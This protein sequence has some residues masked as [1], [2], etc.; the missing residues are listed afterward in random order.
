[1]RFYEF[2]YYAGAAAKKYFSI[3]SR[4][5]LPFPVI[6]IGNITVGGTGKTP[7][8]MAVAE[9]AKRRG[10]RPV[11]LTRGYRGTAKGPCFVAKGNGPSL[12]PEEAGDE[13]YLMAEK[14]RDVAIVKG[15]DRY[16]AGMFAIANIAQLTPSKC[17][18]L[19]ILDDGF[20]HRRL[21]RDEDIVLI[22][23]CNPF[24][25]GKL[26]P[27]GRLREPVDSIADADIIVLT[28]A[29]LPMGQDGTSLS[30][31][32]CEAGRDDFGK[33]YDEIRRHNPASPIFLAGHEPVS[34]SALSGE[35]YPVSFI[36]GR[37]IFAF[38]ALGNPGSFRKTILSSGAELVGFRTYRDHHKYSVSDI[39]AIKSEAGRSGADWIVTTEKD[40]IKIKKFGMPENLLV[41]EIDFTAEKGLYAEVFKEIHLRGDN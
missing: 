14:L 21:Y 29:G 26:L 18:L 4:R 15:G 28:K 31:A 11:I 41:M 1:M 8:A 5:R 7:A 9:E 33:L 40:I 34:L 25:N 3:F 6:S 39:F 23:S 36:S 30:A 13:P 22:D 24:G 19:F 17:P 16:E 35:R 27:F 20:Q 12:T 32:S 10:F 38:C 37:N 2:P